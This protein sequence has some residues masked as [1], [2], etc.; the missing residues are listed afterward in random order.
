PELR[1]LEQR[2]DAGVEALEPRAE[3]P[4]PLDVRQVARRLHGEEEAGRALLDPV[5]DRRAARQPVEGR[6]HLDGVEALRVEAGPLPLGQ[7]GRV[8][9]RVPPV[10]V[11][12]PGAAD[13][14]RPSCHARTVT[15]KIGGS[16]PVLGLTGPQDEAGDMTILRITLAA[17]AA[18]VVASL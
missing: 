17:A 1:R 18:L 15:R 12:P 5:G 3:L 4:Q 7:P 2:L 14:D 16:C 13:P 9:N 8:E 10:G 11:V 6:V